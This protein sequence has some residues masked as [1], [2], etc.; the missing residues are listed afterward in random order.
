MRQAFFRVLQPLEKWLDKTPMY[1]VVSAALAV[2]IASTFVLSLVGLGS[3]SVLSMLGSLVVIAGVAVVTSIVYGWLFRVPAHHLSSLI[4]GMI[5]F[6]VL[7]PATT[8]YEYEVLAGVA[9]VAILSKYLLV[10]RKQHLVNP[11]AISLARKLSPCVSTRDIPVFSIISVS[12][13]QPFAMVSPRR[14]AE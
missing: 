1:L 7:S 3:E 6:L 13:C 14:L 5:L 4:T 12:L 2:V 9:A 10:F 8:V 11:A